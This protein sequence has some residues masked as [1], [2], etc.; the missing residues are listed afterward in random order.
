MTWQCYPPSPTARSGGTSSDG[1]SHWSR[2]PSIW[3]TERSSARSRAVVARRTRCATTRSAVSACRWTPCTCATAHRTG[4]P[5][6]GSRRCAARR[7]SCRRP[8]GSTAEDGEQRERRAHH[9]ALAERVVEERRVV[10]VDESVEL[11]VGEEQQHVVDGALLALVVVALGELLDLGPHVA[12]ERLE[13]LGALDVGG[14]R[15]GSAGSC[16]A[17]TSRPC[18]GRGPWAA[19]T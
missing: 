15:R 19:G 12:Q 3:R 6:R 1:R 7:R 8:G 16:R 11:L 14:R 18:A 5:A 10:L 2:S 9:D 4:R 17:G 13:V